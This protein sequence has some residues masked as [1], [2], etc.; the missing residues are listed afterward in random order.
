MVNILFLSRKQITDIFELF[1][2]ND[3]VVTLYLIEH[4]S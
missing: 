4:R 1:Q 2:G 3:N